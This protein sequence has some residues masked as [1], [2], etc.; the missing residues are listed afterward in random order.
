MRRIAPDDFPAGIIA[1]S[2]HPTRDRR[3]IQ[4]RCAARWSG[5]N[6]RNRCRTSSE[7]QLRDLFSLVSSVSKLFL[8][9]R[10]GIRKT[11]HSRILSTVSW[12]RPASPFS[13]DG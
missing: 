8:L 7:A 6:H 9:L 4:T 3:E 13:I 2:S 12:F 5:K 11:L 10:S 1:I